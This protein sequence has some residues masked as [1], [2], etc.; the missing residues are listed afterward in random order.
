MQS[1]DETVE[2]TKTSV[3]GDFL[4]SHDQLQL[5]CHGDTM[6]KNQLQSVTSTIKSLCHSC[7]FP[8]QVIMR[9]YLSNRVPIDVAQ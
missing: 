3:I 8:L 4:L 7:N 1:E 6:E 9:I 5:L 2:I